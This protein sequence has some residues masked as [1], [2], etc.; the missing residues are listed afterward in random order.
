MNKKDTHPPKTYL[1]FIED[2]IQ[3]DINMTENFA[4]CYVYYFAAE[5][6]KML[7]LD[8]KMCKNLNR[9]EAYDDFENDGICQLDNNGFCRVILSKPANYQEGNGLSG[10][11]MHYR[12]ST[13][14]NTWGKKIHTLAI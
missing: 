11:H 2:L 14:N 8:N 9:S 10:A 6:C 5:S 3:V 4:G 13:K 1:P 7:N 12:I